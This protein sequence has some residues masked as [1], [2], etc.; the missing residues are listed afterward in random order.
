MPW[1]S[2]SPASWKAALVA[3]TLTAL[4]ANVWAWG[5]ASAD[6][7]AVAPAPPPPIPRSDAHA[8]VASAWN[9]ELWPA[10]AAPAP[11]PAAPAAAPTLLA[12]LTRQGQPTVGLRA[13]D[14]PGIRFLTV[15][16]TID[17]WTVERIGPRSATLRR[18]GTVVEIQLA[19]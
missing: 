5:W 14:G 12:V 7:A 1:S 2:D 8:I 17:G 11:V 4:I 16:G 6:L 9:V 18:D 13:A 15:G 10:E 3:A 19:R